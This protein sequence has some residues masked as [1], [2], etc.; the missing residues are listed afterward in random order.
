MKSC[1]DHDYGPL[2]NG[3]TALMFEGVPRYPDTQVWYNDV[4][5]KGGCP[6]VNT[7]RQTETAQMLLPGATPI[8]PGSATL[9]FF[10]L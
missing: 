5:G 9:P 3:L 1:H 8:K 4:L 2:A 6:I 10:G 7:W